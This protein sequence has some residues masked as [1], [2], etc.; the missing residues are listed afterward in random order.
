M[1]LKISAAR[2]GMITGLFMIA[3]TL[4]L[5]YSRQSFDSPFQ[6]LIYGIYLAGIIWTLQS[7]SK[8]N[9]EKKFGNFFLEGF[10]CF[11]TV[12]L[13][14][15]I[16]TFIFNKMH[17]EFKNDMANVYKEELIKQGNATPSEI[18]ERVLKVK[19]YYLTMLISRTI[20]AYLFLGA[21]ITAASSLVFIRRK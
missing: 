13:L 4:I 14:M 5:F 7:F 9:T 1:I 2:K 21:V 10:K 19:D 18:D 20:F 12:T 15:V 8:F 3:L 16:F 6:Y 17:P 11:V